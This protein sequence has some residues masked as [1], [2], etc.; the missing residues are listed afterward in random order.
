MAGWSFLSK[1]GRVLLCIAHDPG[2]RQRD[3]AASLG[4]TERSAYGIVTDLTAAGYA[5]KQKDGRRNR[6]Q[7][8][9]HLP[10][11]EPASQQLTIGEVLALLAGASAGTQLTRGNLPEA[12]A[13][14]GATTSEPGGSGA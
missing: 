13:A 9:A 4:I 5:V 2:V 8:Q 10:P 7:I 6:Y 11:H 3:I 14:A 1:H 12:I